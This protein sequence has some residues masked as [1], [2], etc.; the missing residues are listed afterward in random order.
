M[1]QPLV[2]IQ[3][4]QVELWLCSCFWWSLCL[5]FF[6]KI[7]LVGLAWIVPNKTNKSHS[8]LLLSN[9]PVFCFCSQKRKMWLRVWR[10][11]H[12]SVLAP[13][14]SS[15]SR[16]GSHCLQYPSQ[17][18]PSS[19]EFDLLLSGGK[20]CL[21]RGYPLSGHM[22]TFS[23]DPFWLTVCLAHSSPQSVGISDACLPYLL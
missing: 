17:S 22:K 11:T 19:S 14:S 6:W 10:I 23:Q 21:L 7:E 1:E 16:M 18:C 5:Y 4:N 2:I 20:A 8:L 3:I 15:P 13:W 9:E 12:P